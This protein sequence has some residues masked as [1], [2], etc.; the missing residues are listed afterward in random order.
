MGTAH[1]IIPH[2]PGLYAN[3][4]REEARAASELNLGQA[5]VHGHAGWASSD[6]KLNLV[7]NL[8]THAIKFRFIAK[9]PRSTPIFFVAT[10]LF[11]LSNDHF[12]VVTAFL[13]A[14]IVRVVIGLAAVVVVVQ[15][16]VYPTSRVLCLAL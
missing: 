16:L 13:R 3:E 7:G 14:G 5:A 15:R 10:E 6:A 4:C 2:S 8:A 12:H 11:Q 1:D 9:M